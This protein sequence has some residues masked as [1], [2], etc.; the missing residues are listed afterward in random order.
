MSAWLNAHASALRRALQRIA[1]EPGGTAMSVLVIA[2]AIALPLF[3]FAI[4]ANTSA[5][6]RRLA[7]DPTANVYLAVDAS[8]AEARTAEK[9][10]RAH[11]AVESARFVPREQAL[12]EMKR[13]PNM[14]SLLNAIEGNPLPHALA[15][16][17]KERD[18]AALADLRARLMAL[19][20]VEEVAMDVEWAEKIRRAAGFAERLTLV[21]AG[22]LA[23]AVIFVIANTVRLQIL[24]RRDEIEVCR[25]IGATRAYIRRPFLYLGALQ[26]AAAGVAAVLATSAAT[27]W[28]AGEVR[29]L[30]AAYGGFEVS[31]LSP[32]MGLS[33]ALLA[34]LLGWLGAVISAERHLRSPG[35]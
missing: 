7:T 33:A 13:L 19:P 1:I 35:M 9:A 31:H 21:L 26:G 32:E 17:L 22:V 34:A 30:T 12:E 16:R 11:P 4:V 24:A 8:E 23:L 15:L 14:A 3:L 29:A 27:T 10:A 18:A 20:K 5:A 6:A 2:C 25:L 28:A